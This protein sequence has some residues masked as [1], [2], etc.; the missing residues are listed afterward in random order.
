MV[1]FLC[2][3]ATS[4]FAV[5]KNVPS[6][7]LTIQAGIDAAGTGDTV[8]VE[9]GTYTGPGNRDID[10]KGKAITVQSENGP[11]STIIDCQGLGRGFYFHNNEGKGSV[12][13]GFTIADFIFT[14]M[15][16][17]AQCWPASPSSTVRPA[18]VEEYFV[19]LPLPR[20]AT[21]A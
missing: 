12:L 6:V 14:T 1:A 3:W 2:L 13:A 18:M 7:Y 10:F 15:K 8:L 9:D 17:K 21:A 19:T 5:I 20:L 16:V 11:A 4:T